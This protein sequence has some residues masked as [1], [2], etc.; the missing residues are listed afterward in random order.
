MIHPPRRAPSTTASPP[1]LADARNPLH[2]GEDRLIELAASI[3]PDAIVRPDD[4]TAM[5]GNL[6]HRED[7]HTVLVDSASQR[8]T[9]VESVAAF[10]AIGPAT[11]RI[12]TD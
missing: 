7:L 4:T 2:D 9:G 1:G 12:V 11:V 5:L 3:D 8:P 10:A 6:S